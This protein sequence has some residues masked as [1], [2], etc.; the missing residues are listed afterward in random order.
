MHCQFREIASRA[1]GLHLGLN[2]ALEMLDFFDDLGQF[3]KLDSS[4]RF[5]RDRHMIRRASKINGERWTVE[6]LAFCHVV[7]EVENH[8]CPLHERQAENSVDGDVGTRCDQESAS[9]PWVVL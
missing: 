5:V 4:T 1:T 6:I 7:E 2:V 9:S 3:D 8:P